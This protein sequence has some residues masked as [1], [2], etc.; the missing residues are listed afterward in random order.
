MREKEREREREKEREFRKKWSG[1]I[2]ESSVSIYI[3]I[4]NTYITRLYN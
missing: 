4:S 1:V 2:L 3:N